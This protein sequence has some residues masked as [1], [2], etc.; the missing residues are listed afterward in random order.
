MGLEI[1]SLIQKKFFL[2]TK[3]ISFLFLAVMHACSVTQSCPTL[4][5][6]MDCSLRL[7]CPWDSPGKN[8]GVVAMPFAIS[9][10]TR[11]QN[12]WNYIKVLSE[13]KLEI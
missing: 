6:P 10:N 4:Y 5:N 8:T 3:I 12:K 2:I 13:Y 7:L 9:S 11:C 1:S